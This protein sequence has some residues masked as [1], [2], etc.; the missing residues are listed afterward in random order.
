MAG[1]YK[2]T[3]MGLRSDVNYKR[4]ALY[5]DLIYNDSDGESKIV[6]P[7]RFFYHS[8]PN[9]PTSEV[10]I[11]EGLFKDLFFILGET[12]L[13]TG[14]GVIEVIINPLISFIWLGAFI[15]ILGIFIAAYKDGFLISALSFEKS[16]FFIKKMNIGFIVFSIILAV[17]GY[18]LAAAP[19]LIGGL[20]VVLLFLMFYILYK[21]IR[22][23]NF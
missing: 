23:N 2:V 6:S 18:L 13:D 1:E 14:H 12:D 11:E 19:G 9:Q 20:I 7:A 21:Q 3:F 5:A 10:A 17:A 8:M 4:E 16:S 15:M 22:N